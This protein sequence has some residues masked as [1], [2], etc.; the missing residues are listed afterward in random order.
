MNS[1]I[2]R[3]VIQA[4]VA[5]ITQDLLL[6]PGDSIEKRVHYLLDTLKSIFTLKPKPFEEAVEDNE[7][8][9]YMMFQLKRT[10]EQAYNE[11]KT[12]IL[13]P[14]EPFNNG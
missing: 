1:E 6:N 12:I 5:I 9:A 3:E 2:K 14:L 8:I 11:L 10:D 13:S 7:N 4:K